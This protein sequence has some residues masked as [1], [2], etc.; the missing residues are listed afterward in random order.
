MTSEKNN[1]VLPSVVPVKLLAEELSV[2]PIEVIKKLMQSGVSASINESIDYDTAS[3]IADEF[4]FTVSEESEEVVTEK[5]SVDRDLTLKERPPIVTIMGHVD[6]GKTKLLDAI[7]NTNIIDTESGGIT[8]HIGA[9]QTKVEM[10]ENSEE[11]A[12]NLSEI[13]F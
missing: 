8:Q 4:G 10:E 3:I 11:I 13:G 12:E 2:S 7:R 6:H 5:E 9:Y 1:I